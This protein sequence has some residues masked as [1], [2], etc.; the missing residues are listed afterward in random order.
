MWRTVK[1][2]CF[3]TIESPGYKS[4]KHKK[5]TAQFKVWSV[6]NF[7]LNL[8]IP[9]AR[10]IAFRAFLSIRLC[11]FK[12]K[13]IL[14]INKLRGSMCS[15]TAFLTFSESAGQYPYFPI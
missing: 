6:I 14:K 5:S 10:V 7:K 12:G 9:Q 4:Q 8:D 2:L 1:F 15:G 11:Q 3:M 13:I